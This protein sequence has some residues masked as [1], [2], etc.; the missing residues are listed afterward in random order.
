MARVCKGSQFYLHTPRSS[1][2][3]CLFLPGSATCSIVLLPLVTRWTKIQVRWVVQLGT[4]LRVWHIVLLGLWACHLLVD[5]LEI[6]IGSAQTTM[7]IMLHF[8][9]LQ[10]KSTCLATA[11]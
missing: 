7:G 3:T 4:W 1:T 10:T 9:S 6:W 11:E 8:L 2:H 5:C